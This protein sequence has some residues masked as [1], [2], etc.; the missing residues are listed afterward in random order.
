VGNYRDSV[1][2]TY[3]L[4][5]ISNIETKTGLN[6]SKELITDKVKSEARKI[7]ETNGLYF[8]KLKKKEIEEKIHWYSLP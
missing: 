1:K 6:F 3:S 5:Q 2:T 4:N 8:E 7:I